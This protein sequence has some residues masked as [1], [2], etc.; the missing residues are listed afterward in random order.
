M[1]LIILELEP[2]GACGNTRPDALVPCV[3]DEI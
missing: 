2:M 1:T 3:G